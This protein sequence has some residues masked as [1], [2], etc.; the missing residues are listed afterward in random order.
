M[1]YIKQLSAFFDR[2]ADD[3][4]LNSSHVAMYLSLFQQ[5]N[6]NRFKNPICVD[7]LDLMS[8]NKISSKTT[9]H[10]CIKE[11][12]EYGY[13]VYDPS[14]NPQKGSFIYLLDLTP[15][16]DQNVDRYPTKNQSGTVP[17]PDQK[18]DTSCTGSGQVLDTYINNINI[19]NN[20]NKL[21][22]ENSK[23]TF[24]HKAIP[25]T[26]E[27]V[28]HYFLAQ[29]STKIEA[30]KFFNYF[31]SKGWLIG[32]KAKMKDWK[33]AA[34]NWMLNARTTNKQ[35]TK[36][37]SQNQDQRDGSNNTNHSEPL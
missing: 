3:N 1:N 30:E 20:A 9:Y 25:S 23:I 33:A 29:D 15:G 5:W 11:L 35:N 7:R 32:G 24:P 14:C 37:T 36:P 19:T 27:E 17:A 34:R 31:T 12:H 4:R 21:N 18:T 22:L 8:I 26:L 6:T 13:L 10:K 28:Q 16:A 2:I